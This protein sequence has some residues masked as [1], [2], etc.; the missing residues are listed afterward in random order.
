M[1]SFLEHFKSA[2]DNIAKARGKWHEPEADIES[3]LAPELLAQLRT[4]LSGAYIFE[5]EVGSGGMALVF[6]ARD[7]KHDRE[8]ALKVL[9][10]A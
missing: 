9:P 6:R 2:F 7:L 3:G 8:V 4:A 10:P 1:V 5:Q